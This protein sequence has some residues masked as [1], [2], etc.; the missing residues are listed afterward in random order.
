M[1]H[2]Q[3]GQSNSTDTC[4]GESSDCH[5]RNLKVSD[6]NVESIQGSDTSP[7]PKVQQ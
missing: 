5:T 3:G 4:K 6:T 2:S 1:R 7:C